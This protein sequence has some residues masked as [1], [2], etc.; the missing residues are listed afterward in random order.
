MKRV[1]V[2]GLALCSCV[3]AR[4]ESVARSRVVASSSGAAPPSVLETRA[5]R[6]REEG[7]RGES[8]GY[9]E[10][11]KYIALDPIRT[12]MRG[13]QPQMRGCYEGLRARGRVEDV[14][15]VLR[16]SIEPDGSVSCSDIASQLGGDDHFAACVADAV[17]PLRFAPTRRARIRVSYPV[18]VFADGP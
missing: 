9:D 14:R 6:C 1:I 16:F 13:L 10:C 5:G 2:I 15:V 12:A 18:T 4:G 11:G 3:A 7:S 17:L 8:A